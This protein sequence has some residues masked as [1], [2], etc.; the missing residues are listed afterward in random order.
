[1]DSQ[2]YQLV[3][4][5]GP[6]PG[7]TFELTGKD[8]TIGRDPANGIAISDPEIS[9]KHAR[10]S[11]QAGGYV[12]EDLG[13]TNGTFVN[14]QRLMG[15]HILQPGELI[16]F[17]DNAS[18]VYEEIRI[19]QD[20]T[21]ISDP[22][23]TAIPPI[24]EREP[25]IATPREAPPPEPQVSPPPPVYS[26]QAPPAPVKP[27]VQPS[28]PYPYQEE[29]RGKSRTWLYSGCGCLIVLLCVIVAGAYIVDTLNMWC[30]G[31]LE[32]LWNTFGFVCQ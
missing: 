24:H 11:A 21:I 23:V 9:R 31:P 3:M 5:S 17:A 15:P 13:S 7:K 1:M 18:M 19:D 2:S 22:S 25:V 28:E 6:T 32:P 14:G 26:E 4:R 30:F 10:L 12:L 27:Y 16:M 29:P 20:A 8:L